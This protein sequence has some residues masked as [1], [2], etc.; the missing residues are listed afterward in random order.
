MCALPKVWPKEDVKREKVTQKLQGKVAKAQKH[1]RTYE[2]HC[3]KWGVTIDADCSE[4]LELS[5]KLVAIA[6][7][8]GAIMEAILY[9]EEGKEV[10][11]TQLSRDYT[12]D[13][14]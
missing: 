2:D 9:S 13:A 7:L 11:S 8:E 14:P 12:V 10:A 3:K 6:T 1:G 5:L 4:R